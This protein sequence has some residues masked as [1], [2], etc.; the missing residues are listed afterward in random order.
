M[1]F[2][3]TNKKYTVIESKR[4][5]DFRVVMLIVFKFKLKQFRH[6]FAFTKIAI[7]RIM[8]FTVAQNT[9]EIHASLQAKFS[10]RIGQYLI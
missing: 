8:H 5:S 9:G 3:R 6:D 10:W 1:I 2:R 7:L 4:T